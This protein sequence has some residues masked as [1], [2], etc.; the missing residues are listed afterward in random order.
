MEKAMENLNM[1]IRLTTAL[2][3]LTAMWGSLPAGAHHS[4]AAEFDADSPI[5]LTGVVTKIEWRNPH[6]FFYIDVET[7]DGNF[8]NWALEMGSP[9]GLMRRGWTRDSLQI[10]DEVS[11]EGARAKD[12]SLK[13]NARSVVLSNGERLFAGSSQPDAEDA[14][15]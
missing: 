8:E 9:N 5:S 10:G 7:D 14:E 13:G 1:K 4:F 6:T 11:V 12:G 2:I 3:G 15:R